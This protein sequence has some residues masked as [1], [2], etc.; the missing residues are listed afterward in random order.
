MPDGI[1][2]EDEEAI[3]RKDENSSQVYAFRH[4]ALLDI[5]PP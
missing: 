5:V 1:L 2:L 3:L 4:A